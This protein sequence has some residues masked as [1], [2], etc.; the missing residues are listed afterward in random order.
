MSNRKESSDNSQVPSI[1]DSLERRRQELQLEMAK[2]ELE[3]QGIK[4][5]ESIVEFLNNSEQMKAVIAG[6]NWDEI[7]QPLILNLVVDPKNQRIIPGSYDSLTT[8]SHPIATSATHTPV[9]RRVAKPFGQRPPQEEDYFIPILKA[10]KHFGW[11]ATPEQV[12]PLVLESMRPR[13]TEH[14]FERIGSGMYIRWECRMR[15]ARKHMKDH[16]PPYLNPNSPRGL[17]EATEH[18]RHHLDEME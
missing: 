5:G 7:E 11:S 9:K 15:F 14:D 12:T 17:W 4:V 1:K 18:G 16:N 13:L 3:L 2:T 8:H 10:L 6:L